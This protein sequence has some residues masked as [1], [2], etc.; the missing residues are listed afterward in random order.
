MSPPINPSQS[1]G[2]PK[3]NSIRCN[4]TR[5]RLAVSSRVGVAGIPTF[6]AYFVT[7]RLG[8]CDEISTKY[9]SV[10]FCSGAN[11]MPVSC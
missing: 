5:N 6:C 3:F 2:Y 9:F 11:C 1:G 7:S 10:F 4:S 8:T